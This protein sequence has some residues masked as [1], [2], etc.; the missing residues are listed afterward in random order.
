MPHSQPDRLLAGEWL[1]PGESL[2]SLDGR[3]HLRMSD[4]AATAYAFLSDRGCHAY[5]STPDIPGAD[6]L[7]LPRGAIRLIMKKVNGPEWTAPGDLSNGPNVALVLQHDGNLVQYGAAGRVIW[8][9]D[10]FPDRI[11]G[12]VSV[13]PDSPVVVCPL[14]GVVMVTTGGDVV[15]D[16]TN[17][18]YGG[19]RDGSQYIEVPAGREIAIALPGAVQLEVVSYMFA[20]KPGDTH[21]DNSVTPRRSGDSTDAGAS[22]RVTIKL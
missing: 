18:G 12:P 7:Y 10:L 16:N 1:A 22:G 5:W 2:V 13:P 20:F 4:R 14:P 15:V 6:S 8:A 11:Y 17:G 19:V 9:Y 3:F 21:G